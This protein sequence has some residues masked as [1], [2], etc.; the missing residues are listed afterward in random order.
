M[1]IRLSVTCQ[2]TTTEYA[3][4]RERIGFGRAPSND[5]VVPASEVSAH[6]GV[7]HVAQGGGVVVE[8]SPGAALQLVRG[9]A[10]PVLLGAGTHTMVEGDA[11]RLGGEQGA[12]VRLLAVASAARPRWR[13]WSLGEEALSLGL[14]LLEGALGRFGEPEALLQLVAQVVSERMGVMPARLVLSIFTPEEEFLDDL[15][16]YSP[17]VDG[18]RGRYGV[19]PD[20]LVELGEEGMACLEVLAGRGWFVSLELGARQ[21]LMIGLGRM[22]L[23]AGWLM[24][25]LEQAV[26]EA[27]IPAWGTLLRELRPLAEL[28]LYG[29][30]DEQ[31]ARALAEENTY[32]RE[33]ERRHYLFKELICESESMR[34]VYDQ[35]NQLV[36]G[37]EPVLILGEA[38]SGK[39]LLARAL[40][41]L[42]PG[43]EGMF[44]SLHC[45]RLGDEVLG[46]ELFGC[47]ASELA[48]ALAPRKGVF[49][50]A[51][52]GTVYLDEIDLLSPMMQGK[53]VRMIKEGE[54][55][56]VGDSVGRRVQA[57]LVASTHRSPKELIQSGKLRQDLYILL[58]NGT[59][60]VPALRDRRE[61]LMPLA[62]IFLKLYTKRYNKQIQR[63][64]ED[65]IARMMAHTW[66]G[67]VR[68]LQTFVEATVLKAE[69]GARE[70]AAADL[71]I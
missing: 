5:L 20:P 56:R 41:H 45:G 36:R 25:E 1:T 32:F 66:P 60:E 28:M 69:N 33:R 18:P 71:S 13:A 46:I 44:I 51:G 15:H 61:D 70:I 42:G 19:C 17:G 23:P 38:G 16:A 43:R 37:T 26:E 22:G 6:H 48:G 47:V 24:V 31:R 49:E 21:G 67:N 30:Q 3:F 34:R 68:E 10:S 62:R 55:R 53:L 35:L 65:V 29:R 52:D 57:R 63:F 40:H 58:Q 14:G 9:D 27:A 2:G 59:L 7:L 11:L 8:A 39:E 50:L 12:V 4:D 54:V 64:S